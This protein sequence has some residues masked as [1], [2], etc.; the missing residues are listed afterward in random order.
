[1]IGSYRLFSVVHDKEVLDAAFVSKELLISFMNAFKVSW[2]LLHNEQA[3]LSRD[4]WRVTHVWSYVFMCGTSGKYFWTYTY[5]PTYLLT[6]LLAY[7]FFVI[8]TTSI[9]FT[10]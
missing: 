8:S 5:L 2:H 10:K 6:Y 4:S 7:L 3:T 1:M 9:G